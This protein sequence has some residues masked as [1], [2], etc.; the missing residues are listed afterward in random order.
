MNCS[1][2]VTCMSPLSLQKLEILLNGIAVDALA[3]IV[4]E[5]KAYAFGK[6]IC[7]KIKNSL[8]RYICK[9]VGIYFV[10]III[11]SITYRHALNTSEK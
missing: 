7:Q 6:V 2:V 11:S 1:N 5:K 9:R 8:D 4:H 3:C 10:A